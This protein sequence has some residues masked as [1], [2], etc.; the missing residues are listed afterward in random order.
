VKRTGARA[1]P[2][3]ALELSGEALDLL[4]AAPRGALLAYYA[5]AVPFVLGALFFWA[6]MSH[7]AGAQDRCF[8]ESLL[9]AALF[10]WMKFWQAV[11]AGSLMRH[12]TRA[13]SPPWTAARALRVMARQAAVHAYGLVAIP[14]ALLITFPFGA[15]YAYYQNLTAAGDE[16]TDGRAATSGRA[17]RLALLWPRQNHLLIWLLSPWLLA[18]GMAV[19]FGAVA[20]VTAS[21]PATETAGGMLRVL[22]AVGLASQAIVPLSPVGS[23]V[24]GNVAALLVLLPAVLHRLLGIETS[25]AVAGWRSILN[26]T[27]LATVYA[28]SYL[29]LD[30]VLKAAYVIRGFYGDSQRTGQDLLLALDEERGG[31]AQRRKA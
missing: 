21:L 22:L 29:I 25:F 1:E 7:G 30:P 10:A 27:F 23:V 4:C 17:W 13:P 26:T 28:I 8:A 16:G 15:V 11:F 14:A 5:G 24:A 20:I 31:N 2:K 12:L 9:L 18:A 3:S 6:D 19:A